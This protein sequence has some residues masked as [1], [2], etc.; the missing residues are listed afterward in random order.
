MLSNYGSASA[1]EIFAGAMKDT[2]RGVL[3]GPKGE[4]T[5]G[6]GSVQTI[7]SINKSLERD[8][9]GDMR[10]SG[11]RLTTARYYTPLGK[12]IM[13]EKGINFDISVELPE[14]HELE[15]ARHGLLGDPDQMN[16]DLLPEDMLQNKVNPDGKPHPGQTTINDDKKT[17]GT[18]LD[19]DSQSSKTLE[20][21]LR[22]KDLKELEIQKT[23]K[24]AADAAKPEPVK[25]FH[26]ILLEESVKYLKAIMIFEGRKAA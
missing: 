2:G 26:D 21:I 3:I 14:G 1:S 25:E 4:H 12:P 10:P 18:T 22:E 19:G 16:P 7:S 17:S 6:K 20:Q 5:Y 24:P 23:R 11:I 13:P 15:L 8:S 9:G